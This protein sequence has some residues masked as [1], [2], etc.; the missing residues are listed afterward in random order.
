MGQ[1]TLIRPSSPEAFAFVVHALARY[2]TDAPNRTQVEARVAAAL[3]D[4]DQRR[5]VARKLV[6]RF[7]R[8]P[9]D[10]RR[11]LFG[12]LAEPNVTAFPE[13]RFE[14]AIRSIP[15]A[16]DIVEHRDDVGLAPLPDSSLND[17]Y[18]LIYRGLYCQDDTNEG[19]GLGGPDEPYVI[20]S[21][22]E[23]TRDG[24]NVV[25]TERHPIGSPKHYSDLSDGK[26]RDGPL[27]A[28][29]GPALPNDI[30]LTCTFFEQD[31]GDPDE[32]KDE[33]DLIVTA[34]LAIAIF[35]YGGAG[36]KAILAAIKPLMVE[37]IN[38]L[39]PTAD[40]ELGRQDLVILNGRFRRYGFEAPREFV[41]KRAMLFPSF[42]F[43]EVPT[44]ILHNFAVEN[45][46]GGAHYFACFSVKRWPVVVDPTS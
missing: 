10:R 9:A 4:T 8:V 19:W 40:D 45:K 7:R 16:Q 11:H 29:H 22:A 37:L 39:L 31:Y 43:V 32:Y 27:A 46:G 6:D 36:T 23:I 12:A 20:T 28:C 5:A 33:I 15:A 25:R 18:T 17:R 35:Y 42:Q 14:T 24:Q 2:A 21:V 30:S 38:W 26:F 34:A 3:G 1:R 41:G 13:T 44:P